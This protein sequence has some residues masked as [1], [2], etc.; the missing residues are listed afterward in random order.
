MGFEDPINGEFTVKNTLL[1]S[2]LV[3]PTIEK[4]RNHLLL[5]GDLVPEFNPGLLKGPPP[6]KNKDLKIDEDLLKESSRIKRLKDSHLYRYKSEP[7]YY[8][9][10]RP[11]Y[12]EQEYENERQYGRPFQ[13]NYHD[14]K[15]DI[16]E[17]EYNNRN[18]ENHE[19]G[20]GYS[21]TTPAPSTLP[22]TYTTSTTTTTKRMKRRRKNNRH[23]NE[24]KKHQ[25]KK[26]MKQ[27]ENVDLSNS[28]K[29]LT[30]TT[31]TRDEA[32]PSQ[33]V[34]R[35][36]SLKKMPTEMSSSTLPVRN[37]TLA[38]TISSSK[39]NKAVRDESTRSPELNKLTTDL[40]GLIKL[41]SKLKLS[42]E[43]E[44]ERPDDLDGGGGEVKQ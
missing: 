28:I 14:N 31:V 16:N 38:T 37:S 42:K 15:N 22:T 20:G 10:P 23:R 18:Y 12:T 30:V 8:S 7:I 21:T 44:N 39:S 9:N 5:E 41:I 11:V 1:A 13:S 27:M 3:S 25:L 17:L 36:T 6:P 26:L 33:Q 40:S 32:T 34:V 19:Y 24:K 4:M 29:E 43:S 35:P 2:S